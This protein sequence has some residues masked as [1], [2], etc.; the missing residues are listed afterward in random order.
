[1]QASARAVQAGPHPRKKPPAILPPNAKFCPECGDRVEAKSIISGLLDEPVSALSIS[2][3]LK[4]RVEPSFPTVGN[5]VQATREEVMQ[6]P[7]IKEVR[8]RIIKN[9]ADRS[10]KRRVGKE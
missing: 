9:A 3:R 8:S 1:M 4:K 6:I 7:Y 5:V 2:D 10:E